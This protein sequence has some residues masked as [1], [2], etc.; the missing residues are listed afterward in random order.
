MTLIGIL[1]PSG[2]QQPL[3][4]SVK[5]RIWPLLASRVWGFSVFVFRKQAFSFQIRKTPPTFVGGAILSFAEEEGFEPSVP[6]RA[7]RFSRPPHSTALA[8]LRVWASAIPTTGPP[9]ATNEIR[10]PNRAQQ[11]PPNQIMRKKSVSVLK[12]KAQVLQQGMRGL[13][14]LSHIKQAMLFF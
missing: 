1:A 2:R 11:C 12:N 4:G 3:V 5:A 10:V 7:Q 9:A 6:L 14:H 13:G 8:P